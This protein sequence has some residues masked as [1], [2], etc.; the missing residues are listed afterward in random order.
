M[1]FSFASMLDQSLEIVWESTDGVGAT[2]SLIF[3]LA[4]S[5]KL[6]SQKT[7]EKHPKDLLDS[8]IE[9][10]LTHKSISGWLNLN[11][12]SCAEIYNGNSTSASEKVAMER[13]QDGLNYIATKNVGY[14]F[15]PIEYNTGLRIGTKSKEFKTAP[16]NSILI[17]LEGGSA[18]KK[19]GLVEKEIAFG[20]KL[21][22]VVS[23]KWIDPDYLLMYFLSSK[24]QS[25]FQSQMSGI[26]GGMSKAKFSNIQIP[27]P[28]LAEQK[29]IIAAAKSLIVDCDDLGEKGRVETLL[30]EL[31]RKS[32]LDAVTKAQ[33]TEE[34]LSAW[35]RIQNNWGVFTDTSEA[36][37]EVRTLILDLAVRGLIAPHDF[38]GVSA[39]ELVLESIRLAKK[40][41]GK[42]AIDIDDNFFE[43]PKHW[44]WSTIEELCETQTGTT[45][46]IQELDNLKQLI[47]YVTAADM[48]KLKAVSNQ[49]IPLSAAKRSGRIAP[50]NSVLFVGIGATIGK[51]CSISSPATF[52]QQ[53]HAAT[54]RNIDAEYLCLVVASG[55]FQKICRERTRATAIPILNKSRWETINIPVP[56]LNEQ[57]NIAKTVSGLF[58][59]C[60]ELENLLKIKS[61]IA[62]KFSRSVVSATA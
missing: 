21:F 16:K 28:P 36:L 47:H 59:L 43:I 19:M 7:D 9:K 42:R 33:E 46:K 34:M 27:I 31:L 6:V 24:F 53:I 3:N 30:A 61:S 55:Y 45:P 38:S 26:I 29:R 11:L 54:P 44:V 37:K 52:N 2:K 60:D 51:C 4:T 5:G 1:S 39:K 13:N 15:E 41:R 50:K 32:A 18:G 22:A 20:N 17:C 23:K 58:D 8:I 49:L 48:V 40:K 10:E 14:G 57:K 62:D 12:N 56:P 25:D 35:E